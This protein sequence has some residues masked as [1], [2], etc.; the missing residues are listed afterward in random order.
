M[1]FEKWILIASVGALLGR[2]VYAIGWR[3]WWPSSSSV[4]ARSARAQPTAVGRAAISG[5]TMSWSP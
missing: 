2:T 4:A 3:G 1:R 5:R